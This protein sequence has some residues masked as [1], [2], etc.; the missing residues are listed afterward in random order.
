MPPDKAALFAA[1]G[2]FL[3]GFVHAVRSLSSRS[4]QGHRIGTTLLLAGF[5]CQCLFLAWRGRALGRCPI[6]TPFELLTFVSWAMVLL[7]FVTGTAYRLSLLGAFTAPLALVLQLT[8]LL[9]YLPAH[10]PGRNRPGFWPEMHAT[11]SLI[12]YG[13]FALACVAGVLFL[14]QDRL[15]KGHRNMNL[16]R[17]LPAIHH[18]SGA[19]HRLI[20][21]GTLILSTGIAAAYQMPNR[22][23]AGKLAFVWGIWGIYAAILMYDRWRGMSARRSA[24]AAAIGFL[25]PVL[26]LWIVARR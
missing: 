2:F 23:P 26:S 17:H 22:P 19:V 5:L 25:F 3:A 13:A 18:L 21:T 6:T 10:S 24:W 14:I 8:A 20:L 15:L 16:V 11:L 7:H 12:A 9:R 4:Q 1:S